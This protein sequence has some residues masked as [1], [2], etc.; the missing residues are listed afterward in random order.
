MDASG[1]EIEIKIA[2][3]PHAID[4][5]CAL[6]DDATADVYVGGIMVCHDDVSVDVGDA[7]GDYAC[8]VKA[9]AIGEALSRLN[10]PHLVYDPVRRALIARGIDGKEIVIEATPDDVCDDAFT[11]TGSRLLAWLNAVYQLGR[12]DERDGKGWSSLVGVVAAIRDG[13]GGQG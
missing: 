6:P 3:P 12:H 11:V 4:V 2:I 9:R 13:E 5:L 10:R 7:C 1:F 8:E